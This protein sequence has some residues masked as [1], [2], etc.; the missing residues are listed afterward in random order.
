MLVSGLY[1]ASNGSSSGAAVVAGAGL[2]SGSRGASGSDVMGVLAD[3][4]SPGQKAQST[5]Q[6]RAEQAETTARRL[7][8]RRQG[9]G[10]IKRAP[11]YTECDPRAR[12]HTPDPENLRISK[13]VWE[14]QVQIWR[15]E[16]KSMYE[17]WVS[18]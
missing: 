9:I 12:P 2:A 11:E 17:G 1:M 14:K 13:R 18:L 4:H 3:G 16:L 7:R 15:A 10:A 6:R 5:A 8:K